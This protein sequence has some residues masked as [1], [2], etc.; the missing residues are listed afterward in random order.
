MGSRQWLPARHREVFAW[1]AVAPLGPCRT[2]LGREA[3]PPGSPPRVLAALEP[4]GSPPRVLAALEPPG[5]RRALAAVVRLDLVPRPPA[6]EEHFPV[7]AEAGR[8][9]AREPV[10]PAQAQAPADTGSRPGAG[11]LQPPLGTGLLQPPLGT[12]L[13]Q[14]PLG[15]GQQHLASP[16]GSHLAPRLP[17]PVP[18][19][20]RPSRLAAVWLA[21]ARLAGA[22]LPHRR[23]TSDTA[24]PNP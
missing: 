22:R 7:E 11:L 20:E 12:G 6:F 10:R 14:P 21:G 9:P 16:T 15:T 5:R 1:Q 18:R 4:P 2:R 8:R 17:D 23:R 24:H 19:P 13:L 3:E